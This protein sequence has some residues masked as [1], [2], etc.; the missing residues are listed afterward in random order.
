[1][2]EKL[3][4]DV[5]GGDTI[6]YVD[7][8]GN[9]HHHSVITAMKRSGIVYVKINDK[10]MSFR[11]NDYGFGGYFSNFERAE[12]LSKSRRRYLI[13]VRLIAID[14]EIKKRKKEKTKLNEEYCSLMTDEDK[15]QQYCFNCQCEG[16]IWHQTHRK[17]EFDE[18][19]EKGKPLYGGIKINTTLDEVLGDMCGDEDMW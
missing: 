2:S 3:F 13:K 19:L 14:E 4:K 12:K 1:M 11:E 18:W 8:N 15:Y 7:F 16:D 10:N 9:I 17:Y 5:K 6:Y